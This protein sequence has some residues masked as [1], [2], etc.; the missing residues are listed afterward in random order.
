MTAPKW[1]MISNS[2]S[3]AFLSAASVEA[4]SLSSHFLFPVHITPIRCFLGLQQLP[5][6][7][8]RGPRGA[9]EFLESQRILS[10][11]STTEL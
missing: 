2:E 10:W 7:V 5:F 11:F 8:R 9:R 6:F 3:E 1:C 4:P